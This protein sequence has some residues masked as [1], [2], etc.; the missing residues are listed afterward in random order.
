MN[1]TIKFLTTLLLLAVSVGAWADNV[2]DELTN[3]TFGVT[4]TT[5]TYTLVKN[6]RAI[7]DAVYAA[8]L[9]GGNNSI[10]LR[11]NN[12]NSGIV[13]TTSGGRLVSVSIEFN[14][15]TT[16]GRTVTVYGSNKAFTNPSELYGVNNNIEELGRISTTSDNKTITVSG[17]Y[18]YVG[19]RSQSGA[20]YLDKVIIEWSVDENAVA[21]TTTIDDS[22]ITNTNVY[23]STTAGSLSA[24][25]SAGGNA[26]SG[27]TVSWSSSN[28]DV[29][30]ID[31]NGA[32]TLVAAG[33]ATITASYAGVADQYQA[34]S[35]TYELTVTS[36]APHVQPTSF[37]IALND[38][39]F[40]TNYG[41]SASGITDANPA[42]GIQE[43]VT[44]T[45]AGSGNH[46]INS[47]QIRFYPNNNLTFEAPAGYNITKIVFT[48]AGTW[49]ATITANNG[50]YTSN[51][52][53]WTG[54]ATSVLFTGSGSSRCD[55]S[56][57]TIT[58]DVMSTDPII[59][60]SNPEELTYNAT[61]GEFGYSITNPATG[62]SLSATSNTDWIT[63][64]TVD[65]TNSKVTFTTS[66]NTG[67]QRTGTI[68]LSY[69][70]A[71]DKVVTITQAAA[72]VIYTTIPALFEA[73]TSDET[74]VNV[75][76]N[77]WVVSGV[78]TSGKNVFVTDN[79]GNGF[80]IYSSEDVSSTYSAGNIL[81]GTAVPCKLK[82]Y[83]GFAEL[84]NVD[85]SDL[86]ITSGGTVNTSNI[87]MA[88]LAGVNTGALVS[89]EGL[90]CS[91]NDNKYYLSDGTTTIQVYNALYNFE[92]LVNGKQYNITG[93]YQQYN[94]TK[95]ILPRSAAD[96]E[97]VLIPVMT[98]TPSTVTVDAAGGEDTLP[99]SFENLDITGITDFD[100]QYCDA[101]GQEVENNPDWI[102]VEVIDEQYDNNVVSYSIAANE[103][104][105][106]TA[107]FKVIAIGNEGW[108]Y[109]NLVTITQAAYVAPVEGATYTLAN[110]IT[111]GKHYIIVGSSTMADYAMGVQNNN[112]R[113]AV[114]I[115]I[116][117]ETATVA[118]ESVHEVQICG[119]D[120]DGYY[121]IYDNGY[122]YAASSGSNYLRTET[123]LDDNGR[124]SIA[125]GEGGVASIIA[126]G[127]NERN[128]MQ[129]NAS[130]HIFAC[131]ASASQLP[132]YLYEKDG[133]AT[134]TQAVSISAAGMATFCSENA[135]DFTGLTD[136][137]AYIALYNNNKVTY[138]KVYKVPARTGV[139][140][141]NPNGGATSQEV[142][143]LTGAADDVEGN[144]FIG[145][146][147]EISSL[148]SVDGNNTNYI[149]NN[150]E[151]G[152]G[153]YK[154]AGKKVG[155]GKAYLQIP[156]PA[157]GT[158]VFIGFEET[159]EATGIENV[160][161]ETT[162]N[163]R[164]YN[165]NGQQ[166]S[167]NYKG[168][169]I[170]NGKKTIVK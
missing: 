27:A 148:P 110:S 45:Y 96:I 50:T 107:Y 2:T 126:K 61:S 162:T 58:L 88:D 24:T 70:G 150:G 102:D 31:E 122:L 56:K 38:T 100:I 125:F 127:E 108:I 37:D 97:E 40:G 22:G 63:N 57:A 161:R 17:D 5:T 109:S 28:T 81:S 53:T 101:Q 152:V 23:T 64:V 136:M 39:F 83:N 46:Y 169:V 98:V 112:N 74:D 134:P 95:E 15:N 18:K 119:P 139:M 69:I 76:F 131:Y 151:N 67:D 99:I 51:T 93:I 75:T 128:H 66:T 85:A 9:A 78:S 48:S 13:S 124:W 60:A 164:C 86:T 47:T 87:A 33:T 165:L 115:E 36:S 16:S 163:G 157:N 10:Q 166:V 167:G 118:S 73:A 59:V 32:I 170:V 113:A 49:A 8:N 92:A 19:I 135:L 91:V 34:S 158:K 55:M 35:D 82:K 142:P 3:S 41:G 6:K 153:F 7:S 145:T 20:L 42:I 154:A 121:T 80:V 44:V 146:L 120:A 159:G 29:A 54:E 21:T 147:T 117:D 138:K 160:N 62:V 123:T 77:N 11:T 130:N 141:R 94:S 52:K 156:T 116:S 132:I 168:I 71:T 25:V 143:V 129:F 133:E 103:G 89:Y 79:S 12:N 149:L 14:E 26:I 106:R 30:T 114:E 1:K 140:L 90:T 84:I 65:E 137:Y 105:A 72:P 43:G 111:S 104:E 155:A 144:K 4:S 68:T